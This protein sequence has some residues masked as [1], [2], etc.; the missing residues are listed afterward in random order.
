MGVENEKKLYNTS[1]YD[2]V[3]PQNDP[4][5]YELLCVCTENV[6]L[7]DTQTVRASVSNIW[8]WGSGGFSVYCADVLVVPAGI[9][10]AKTTVCVGGG[11]FFI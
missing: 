6:S 11:G 1:V 2:I 5:E 8:D 7:R 3:L 9:D 10:T 4:R